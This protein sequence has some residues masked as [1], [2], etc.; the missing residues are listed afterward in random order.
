MKEIS[1]RAVCHLF[2]R[3]YTKDIVPAQARK[4]FD[5]G[6]VDIQKTYRIL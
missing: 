2:N 5:A 4:M 3:T 6:Q 1:E